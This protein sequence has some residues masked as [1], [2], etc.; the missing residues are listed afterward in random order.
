MCAFDVLRAGTP[1]TLPSIAQRLVALVALHERPVRRD[2]AAGTLWPET[3]DGRA[4]GN[5]RSTLWRVQKRVPALLVADALAIHL[6]EGVEL[7]LRR[8]E[9]CA[10]AE[11]AG[12]DTELDARLLAGDL[13]PGWYED[14]W[15][16]LERERF[17]QLRLQA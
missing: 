14:D 3:T 2:Y 6:N 7:D 5:L 11:L 17:R 10:H 9:S 15:V 4:A 16:L 13:L 8:A 12:A 1:V